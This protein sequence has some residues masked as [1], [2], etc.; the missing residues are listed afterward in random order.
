MI[1]HSA[2]PT[3]RGETHLWSLAGTLISAQVALPCH[4]PGK[5][6]ELC[7]WWCSRV[8]GAWTDPGNPCSAFCVLGDVWLET[9]FVYLCRFPQFAFQTWQTKKNKNT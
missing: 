4:I 5:M 7:L 2:I 3:V 1:P 9:A 6:E 8:R